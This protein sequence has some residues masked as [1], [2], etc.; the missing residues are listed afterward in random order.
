MSSHLPFPFGLFVSALSL[1]LAACVG[2][3]VVE[4]RA[5]TSSDIVG[6]AIEKGA[7]SA[8]YLRVFSEQNGESR[9]GGTLF[10]SRL[11]LTA[12]HCF[13]PDTTG[14]AFGLGRFGS[15]DVAASLIWRHPAF[16]GNGQTPGTHDIA[17]VVLERAIDGP[18][19]RTGATPDVDTVGFAV[20]YGVVTADFNGGDDFTLSD[21]LKS[22]K[23]K[24]SLVGDG[25]FRAVG[26]TGAGC[27][28]DSGSAF[29]AADKV[30]LLGIQSSGERPCT[31]QAWN[32]FT[33]VASESLFVR[34][35]VQCASMPSARQC[36]QGAEGYFH[37]DVQNQNGGEQR[38][39]DQVQEEQEQAAEQEVDDGGD[40][41]DFD[42]LDDF[43]F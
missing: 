7:G 37:P 18:S 12:A 42:D 19:A 14:A 2:P 24:V 27:G 20:G 17:A 4:D 10:G 40:V 5:S 35:A 28:G 3:T 23:M 26:V 32:V 8:G 33:D 36:F 34:F 30:T 39:A 22:G 43:D 41:G 25:A 13:G 31:A 11:V 9:C 6:G 1:T 21:D 15:A 29:F 38:Q 16:A